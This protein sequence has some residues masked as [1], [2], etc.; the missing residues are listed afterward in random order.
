[1]PEP[2]RHGRNFNSR[3]LPFCRRTLRRNEHET[4]I[5]GGNFAG[6]SV[7]AVAVPRAASVGVAFNSGDGAPCPV[8]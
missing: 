1:M 3:Y 6:S 7:D 4:A 8:D 5:D 2:Y